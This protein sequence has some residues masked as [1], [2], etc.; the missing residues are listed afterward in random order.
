MYTAVVCDLFGVEERGFLHGPLGHC[1]ATIVGF[2][3]IDHVNLDI[4][5]L[6][7]F[8]LRNPVQCTASEDRETSCISGHGETT[9]LNTA[10]TKQGCNTAR[11]EDETHVSRWLGEDYTQAAVLGI[12]GVSKNLVPCREGEVNSGAV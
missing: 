10:V 5:E 3:Y 2:G 7:E 12:F 11:W 6:H 9:S 8:G 1:K 4:M